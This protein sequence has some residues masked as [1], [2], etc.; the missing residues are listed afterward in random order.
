MKL[1]IRI[2]GGLLVTIE[3]DVCAADESVGIMSPG[4]ENW[5]VVAINDRIC[6]THPEWLYACIEKRKGEADRIQEACDE[7]ATLYYE[8]SSQ[9]D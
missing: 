6:K 1:D 3:F 5:H 4:A 8:D 9:F 7:A 2:L